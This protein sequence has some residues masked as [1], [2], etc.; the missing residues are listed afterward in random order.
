M[1]E[2]NTTP[3]PGATPPAGKPNP[4]IVS[5]GQTRADLADVPATDGLGEAGKKALAEER[6]ARKALEQQIKELQDRDPVKAIAEAIG[7]KPSDAK[8]DDLA[9]TVKQ[10]QQQMRDAELRAIRLEVA[11][12]KGLTPQQAARLQGATREELAADADSLKAL[13]PTPTPGTPAPDPSQG[14]RGGANDLEARLKA[15]QEKG[16]TRE[17]IRLKTALAEQKRT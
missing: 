15:A 5:Q 8:G 11:A 6:A 12:D 1:T 17:A 2:P 3:E 10:M 16:D 13:F 14:A 4:A 9:A 7:L